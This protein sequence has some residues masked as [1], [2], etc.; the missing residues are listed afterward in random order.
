MLKVNVISFGVNSKDDGNRNEILCRYSYVVLS[1][2]RVFGYVHELRLGWIL[3][4]A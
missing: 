1:A 4:K 2:S 3:E